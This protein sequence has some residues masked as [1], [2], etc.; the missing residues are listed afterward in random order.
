[1]VKRIMHIIIE[2]NKR[3]RYWSKKGMKDATMGF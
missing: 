3:N 2:R 1:M